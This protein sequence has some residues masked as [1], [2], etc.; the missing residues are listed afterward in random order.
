M[1]IFKLSKLTMTT[2][3]N[4]IEYW[5]NRI[6]DGNFV[7][8]PFLFLKL[9]PEEW[10]SLKHRLLMTLCFSAYYA[11]AGLLKRLIWN[12]HYMLVHLQSDLFNSSILFFIWF[13]L[14]TAYF[15]NR[16]VKRIKVK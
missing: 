15:W 11:V 14:V 9:K 1:A 4:K 5:H 16:R 2:L 6:S 3:L 8:F 13:N 7:W 10:M 12:G